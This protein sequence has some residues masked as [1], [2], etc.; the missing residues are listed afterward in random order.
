MR[1]AGERREDDARLPL[2]GV[3]PALHR[4]RPIPGLAR[5]V[6]I[7]RVLGRNALPGQVIY[8]LK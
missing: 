8:I 7:D 6:I 3:D 2:A 1:V 4:G 5:Y